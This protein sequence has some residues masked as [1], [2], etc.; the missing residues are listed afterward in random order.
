MISL[1]ILELKRQLQTYLNRDI[2]AKIVINY[3][4]ISNHTVKKELRMSSESPAS[5][6]ANVVS[7]VIEA[8][9]DTPGGLL[10]TLHGIQD[11]IGYI[12]SDAVPLI[13]KGLNLSRA[14]V[15]GVLTYYPH[16]RQHK[17][18]S[19][20]V[21]VCRAEACQS[22]GS[23]ELEAHVKKAVRCGFHET[24]VDGEVTLEPVYCLGHCAVGPNISID[25]VVHARVTPQQFDVLMSAARGTK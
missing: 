10:P 3:L 20:V 17:P 11:A 7:H 14:E 13:A 9:K 22:V 6:D 4:F 5:W 1:D 15:H 25:D 8:N 23:D 24:S 12:P 2:V 18:G 19:H 21:Q 16:F